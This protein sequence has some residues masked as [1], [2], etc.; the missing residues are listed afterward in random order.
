M[1]QGMVRALVLTAGIVIGATGTSVLSA[2][3]LPMKPTMLIQ[4]DLVGSDGKQANMY[5]IE[6]QPG[7]D[8]G[9]HY[10]P[11]HTFVYVL[12][13]EL[14]VQ[15]LDTPPITY[16]PGQAFHEPPR[17]VHDAKSSSTTRPLKILVFQ[18]IETGQPLAVP[19]K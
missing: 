10:H 2:Q 17:V 12:E 18:A 3:H 5:T 1:R 6:A 19:V 9:R 4:T 15:Q 8:L 14:T 7:V 16:R 11:G 13:G